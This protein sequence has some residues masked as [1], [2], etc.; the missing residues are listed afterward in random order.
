MLLILSIIM[1]ML[2]S[3]EII[4]WQGF[5]LDYKW[6]SN[7]SLE[8]DEKVLN[9]GDNTLTTVMT[10]NLITWHFFKHFWFPYVVTPCWPGIRTTGIYLVPQHSLSLGS[11]VR[12]SSQGCVFHERRKVASHSLP[13]S[14][15]GAF[16]KPQNMSAKRFPTVISPPLAAFLLAALPMWSEDTSDRP[17]KK[18]S[19]E[20]PRTNWIGPWW[21]LM[22]WR[23]LFDD[24][25][26]KINWPPLMPT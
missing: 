17:F 4:V 19:L 9:L 8:W 12:C 16:S 3:N 22:T 11:S 1:S 21:Q 7:H 2:Q 24:V 13:W 23:V 5:L 20:K 10:N 25:L 26:I 18:P 15:V 6:V 14:L